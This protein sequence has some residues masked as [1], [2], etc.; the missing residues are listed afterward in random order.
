[1]HFDLSLQGRDFSVAEYGEQQLSA[2]DHFYR[3]M[4]SKESVP[5]K[6][7]DVSFPADPL[8]M[9]RNEAQGFG[10]LDYLKV[11]LDFEVGIKGLQIT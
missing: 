7:V 10:T 3:K 4:R 9:L 6:L 8:G 1:M 11:F 2:L 5:L